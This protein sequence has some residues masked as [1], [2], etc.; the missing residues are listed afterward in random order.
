M[1]GEAILPGLTRLDGLNQRMTILFP[2]LAGMSVLG[3][4]TTANH[5]ALETSPEMHP[6]VSG[7]N[8]SIANGRLG[9]DDRGQL[10]EVVT[11]RRCHPT[12]P[13]LVS[14]PYGAL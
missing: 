4:V 5:P 7:G 1:V 11:R 9:I 8:T 13:G 6:G 10:S 14:N 12:S 2:M 3:L